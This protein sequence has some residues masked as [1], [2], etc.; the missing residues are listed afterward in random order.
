MQEQTDTLLELV[1]AAETCKVCFNIAKLCRAQ[2]QLALFC[3]IDTALSYLSPATH[4]IVIWPT[5]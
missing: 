2:Q 1:I 5:K 3:W 4:Y